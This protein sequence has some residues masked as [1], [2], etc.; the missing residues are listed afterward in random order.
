M[1][2][3]LV[4]TTIHKGRSRA[5]HR[6]S[7]GPMASRLA[8]TKIHQAR[9]RAHHRTCRSRYAWPAIVSLRAD[10]TGEEDRLGDNNAA[11]LAL[12]R[13]AK[14]AKPPALRVASMTLESTAYTY[15]KR[16]QSVGGGLSSLAVFASC[17]VKS[18]CATRIFR[19]VFHRFVLLCGIP[20][21]YFA[22]VRSIQPR[23][24]GANR[25]HWCTTAECVPSQLITQPS[26]SRAF[27]NEPSGPFMCAGTR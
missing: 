24:S 2:S 8:E 16:T 17:L 1:A 13:H 25:S 27:Q 21:T 3:H 19:N 14:H 22:T 15:V 4:G 7:S 23:I 20:C 26:S 10:R 9:S 18:A 6:T 11:V 5:P 12:E